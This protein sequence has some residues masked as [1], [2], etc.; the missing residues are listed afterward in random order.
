MAP[1]VLKVRAASLVATGTKKKDLEKGS[2]SITQK[3]VTRRI[4]ALEP[5]SGKGKG[6]VLLENS[7][8]EQDVLF[9]K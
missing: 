6:K 9:V 4:A 1:R 3:V 7:R 5:P 8:E 2:N